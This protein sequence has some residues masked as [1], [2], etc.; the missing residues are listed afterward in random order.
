M[1]LLCPAGTA[2][3]AQ[4][5][6]QAPA[7]IER[8][9]PSPKSPYA[10]PNGPERPGVRGEHLAQWMNQHSNLSPQQ[11]QQALQQ[12]R[13]FQSLPSSTQQRYL[14]R[15]AQLNAMNPQR[16]QRVLARTEAMER[17]DPGQRAEV[18]GAMSQ[19]GG[20][21]QDERHA[22]AQ[23]FRSLRELPPEQRMPAYQSGR[24]GPPLN[25]AQQAALFN[26]LRVEPLMGSMLMPPPR[27]Q[28][29]PGPALGFH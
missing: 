25:S 17:L 19:L 16:R 29:Q 13:G 2:G 26:L 28:Q 10:S 21:P 23:T 24:Y 27:P 11:Q 22:V 3:L 5:P 4:T 7:P 20:L 12:E 15:L 6:Q 8:R 9:S 1:L 18:R 14:E